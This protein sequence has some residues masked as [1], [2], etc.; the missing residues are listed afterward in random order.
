VRSHCDAVGRAF[1]TIE[2]T[3]FTQFDGDAD[4]LLEHLA[5]LHQIDVDHVVVSGP[6]FEWGT[7]LDTQSVE[8]VHAL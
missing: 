7:E 1:D 2:K 8:R 6:E 5:E 3:V 4:D